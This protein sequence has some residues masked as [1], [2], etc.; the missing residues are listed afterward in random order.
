MDCFIVTVDIS[1]RQ[2]S[3]C[4][5]MDEVQANPVFET[6]LEKLRGFRISVEGRLEEIETRLSN[7]Q[8]TAL[9]TRADVL[10]IKKLLRNHLNLPV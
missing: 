1:S 10:E 8:A 3:I 2:H 6:I 5:A 9:D 7:L 4:S